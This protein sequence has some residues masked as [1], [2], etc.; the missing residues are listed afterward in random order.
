MKRKAIVV[1]KQKVEG[2]RWYADRLRNGFMRDHIFP[3]VDLA[4]GKPVP[5][6]EAS[7]RTESGGT[8]GAEEQPAAKPTRTLGPMPGAERERISNDYIQAFK[9]ARIGIFGTDAKMK[10]RGQGPMSGRQ[11]VMWGLPDRV[12]E[13]T[14]TRILKDFKLAEEDP[15]FA[16]PKLVLR[17]SAAGCSFSA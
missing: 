12:K 11:V 14:W 9:D 8:E 17:C 10:Q 1:A 4:T 3:P 7:K 5:R 13:V 2:D 16:V 15:I 6:N